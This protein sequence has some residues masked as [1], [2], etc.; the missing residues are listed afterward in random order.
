MPYLIR[1]LEDAPDM[2]L[3]TPAQRDTY[4]LLHRFLIVE[5]KPKVTVETILR[6]LGIP[7]R[8]LESRLNHLQEKGFLRWGKP[9]M[10]TTA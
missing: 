10:T 5:Q 4:K 8:C 3:A 6:E 9:Q 1:F 7:Y 2:Q